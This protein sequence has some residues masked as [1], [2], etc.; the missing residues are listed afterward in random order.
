LIVL[1]LIF[2]VKNQGDF[3]ISPSQ[4]NK[5]NSIEKVMDIFKAFIPYNQELS[6]TQISVKLGLH[7]ATASRILL[8]LTR[9]DFLHQDPVTKKFS[10]G[11]AALQVGNA[12]IQ[13]LDSNLVLIAKPFI[14]EL[15]GQLEE[16]IALEAFSGTQPIMAYVANTS[17]SARAAVDVGDTMPSHAAAGAK[18]IIAFSSRDK[19]ERLI[20]KELTKL[21]AN[22][23]TDIIQ[24]KEQLAKVR[25]SGYAVDMGEIVF[26]I[27]AIGVPIFNHLECP[28]GAVV[29]IG[30]ETSIPGE[31]LFSLVENL[32]GTAALIS[33]RLFYRGEFYKNCIKAVSGDKA[34]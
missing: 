22:T 28:V 18:A 4:K 33:A 14:D 17:L 3:T 27:N 8:T 32:M 7:R 16:T 20:P 31:R 15:R 10:L 24:L 1:A 30:S 34:L 12:L 2:F 19:R 13:S 5:T 11:G 25:Q 26:G 21:T 9:G 23:I 6:T 29:V